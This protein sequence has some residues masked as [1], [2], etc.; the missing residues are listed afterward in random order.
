MKTDTTNKKHTGAAFP[1]WLWNTRDLPHNNSYGAD[2]QADF[3]IQLACRILPSL[4]FKFYPSY[5]CPSSSF[6]TF[7]VWFSVVRAGQI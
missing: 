1:E 5:S 2:R 7:V 6:V 3:D 4:P